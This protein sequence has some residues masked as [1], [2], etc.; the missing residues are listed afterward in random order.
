MNYAAAI[1]NKGQVVGALFSS[2]DIP[3]AGRRWI[4]GK[5][6]ALPAPS[7]TT[8]FLPVAVNARGVIAGQELS[9]TVSRPLLFWRGR[10]RDLSLARFESVSDI[11]DKG[12]LLG[13]LPSSRHAGRAIPAY[14]L[15][16]GRVRFLDVP[17]DF[18][19]IGAQEMS[20]NGIII[21]SAFFLNGPLRDSGEL[22][23]MVWPSPETR[24]DLGK[25]TIP[26]AVNDRGFVVGDSV[27]SEGSRHLSAAFLW[28]SLHGKRQ[29]DSLLAHSLRG[30]VHI[31][32]AADINNANQILVEV[33]ALEPGGHSGAAILYPS[34][35][36]YPCALGR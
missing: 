26:R 24:A 12:I 4:S 34:G 28:D 27:T 25:D 15:P 29:L 8:G 17:Q 14:M 1:N 19:L 3:P 22:R 32:A 16:N 23:G 13:A 30:N 2:A 36:T 7:P 35:S 11:T 10:Y 18:L 6:S 9:P 33:Q 20:E 5:L 21:G 31:S